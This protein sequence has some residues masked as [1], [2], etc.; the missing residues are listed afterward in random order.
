[1]LTGRGSSKSIEFQAIISSI[2]TRTLHIPFTYRIIMHTIRSYI[3]LM[4]ARSRCRVKR[5]AHHFAGPVVLT[6][7]KNRWRTLQLILPLL[8][9]PPLSGWEN[10]ISGVL[11]G[12]S[13]YASA[14]RSYA[15]G[16]LCTLT[17]PSN[18]T[19]TPVAYSSMCLGCPW[20]SSYRRSCSSSQQMKASMPVFF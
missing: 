17:Y 3:K 16:A 13:R 6:D 5:H 2:M 10:P 19:A 1:M 7:P 15:Y 4:A 14:P 20:F 18:V 9:T 12:S 11:G 8:A